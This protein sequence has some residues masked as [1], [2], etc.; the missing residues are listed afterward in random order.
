MA[1]IDAAPGAPRG[2]LIGTGWPAFRYGPNGEAQIFQKASDVPAGWH[3]GM[4]GKGAVV[5]PV[6]PARETDAGLLKL[7]ADLEQR[8]QALDDRE[9]ALIARERECD[10]REAQPELPMPVAPMKLGLPAKT[11]PKILKAAGAFGKPNLDAE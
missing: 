6:A 10:A 7:K 2:H 8:A 11:A 9:A 1:R 3:D 4:N 5:E